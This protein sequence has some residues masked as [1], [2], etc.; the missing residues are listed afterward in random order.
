MAGIPA[1][2][3]RDVPDISLNSSPDHDGYLYCTQVQTAASGGNY[4]SS[5]QATSF[6]LA[7]GDHS[8]NNNLT[9]AGG[10]SFAAPAFSGL[11]AIIEQKL[12][13]GG[14]LGNIN[15]ALY[16]I[17]RQCDHLCFGFPRH[18]GWEQP[19]A[20]RHRFPQLPQLVPTR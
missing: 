11:L 9:V 1:D 15:P 20:L 13:S 17:G 6:R 8:D 10:T 5:C 3:H 18:H 4:V 19:G 14:G 7:D 2:G 16:T 12:G